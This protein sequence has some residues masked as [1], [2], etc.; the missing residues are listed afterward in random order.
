MNALTIVAWV[1]LGMAILCAVIIALDILS[2]HRQKM[3]IM[4]VVWPVTAL[5]AGPLAL[6]AYYS[7]GRLSTQA[8]MHRAEVRGQANPGKQKP[9]WQMVAV[10]ATHCGAGCTLGDLCAE[11]LM[12]ALPLV[13]F[14][15]RLFGSW[16]VDYVF[17]YAFG[18]AF[19][20]FTIVPMRHL[21]VGKGIWAAVKADTLSLTAWQVGMYGWMA[22][23]VFVIFGHELEKTDP[24]FWFMMQIAMLCG[25]LTAYPVNWW[26]LKQGWKEKM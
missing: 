1:S 6:W 17:A 10:G 5:Y 14:G 24:V 8:A 20:Y 25:F 18:I 19:Q 22:I 15:H 3:W 23:A 11:W 7:V 21:P 13:L 16:V 4:N 12:F 2:G 9:F 26:L